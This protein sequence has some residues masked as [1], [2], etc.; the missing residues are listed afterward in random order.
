[1]IT[2]FVVIAGSLL[3]A[4][5]ALPAAPA[6]VHGTASGPPPTT[7][8]CLLVSNLVAKN[9]ND[10]KDRNLAQLSLQ[11]FLGR[12]DERTSPQQLK[13]DLQQK[14]HLI[15]KT[16]ATSLMNACLHQMQTKS[17]MLQS[18]AQELQQTR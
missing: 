10:P 12:I 18:V 7:A 9:A 2:R 5:S 13:S 16:N 14:G 3:I 8:G 4:A 11:F 1:M 15:T 17:R 6:V